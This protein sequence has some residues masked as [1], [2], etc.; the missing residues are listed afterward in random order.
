MKKTFS[1]IWLALSALF[2]YST[3]AHATIT[4]AFVLDAAEAA[5]PSFVR[6]GNSLLI[7]RIA[8]SHL[9]SFGT[10]TPTS[11]GRKMIARVGSGAGIATIG[12][13]AIGGY[14]AW[15]DS[16]PS[17]FPISYKLLHPYA[18]LYPPSSDNLYPNQ[19]YSI[20][21]VTMT[22]KNGVYM[23]SYCRNPK[24]DTT[25]SNGYVHHWFSGGSG[26]CAPPEQSYKYYRFEAVTSSVPSN[27]RV[28]D[29]EF[30]SALG[31][32]YPS[33]VAEVD[34]Y[35][36]ANPDSVS[37]PADLQHQI[38]EAKYTLPSIHDTDSDGVPDPDDDDIDGDGIP[39]A[40]DSDIDG[41]G[42]PNSE[43]VGD[44]DGP[45]PP[46]PPEY[47]T[48]NYQPLID[49]ADDLSDKFP[50]TL[51][52]TLTNFGR[53][54]VASPS[55][56]RFRFTF[57]APFNVEFDVDL[58]RFDGIASMVRTLIAMTILAYVTMTLIRRFR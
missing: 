57:P 44:S 38:D 12:L 3:C 16:H 20:S 26:S 13:V 8:T 28:T 43:D 18:P 35:I 50:F 56:P 22:V 10:A 45:A 36:L 17:D 54:L 29:S 34:K 53:S 40:E 19:V 9:P 27:I 42:V 46:E 23:G 51:F 31:E 15:V 21:G 52:A 32:L 48:V 2:I 1:I 49:M 14:A 37:L 30:G 41:D 5:S 47:D 39:N 4:K 11:I 24:P 55:A 6:Y 33:S 7:P 25:Y 58:S